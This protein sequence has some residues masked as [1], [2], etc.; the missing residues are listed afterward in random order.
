MGQIVFQVL[1]G[2]F[3]RYLPSVGASPEGVS[4]ASIILSNLFVPM[5]ERVTLPKHLERRQRRHEREF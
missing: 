2:T 5:I 3:N 4:Y 1:F